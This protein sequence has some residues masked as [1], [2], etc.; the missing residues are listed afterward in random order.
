MLTLPLPLIVALILGFLATR[1]LLEG[2]RSGLFLGLLLVCALQALIVSLTQHYGVGGLRAVQPVT[3]T[4]APVLA[5]LSFQ[6]AALRP[7]SV[8][9]DW[10][11]GLSPV[12]LGLCVAVA[13]QLIDVALP[14]IFAGYA[15]AMFVVL[16]RGEVM[17]RARLAAGPVPRRLWTAIAVMLLLS[18]ASDVLISVAFGLGYGAWPPII[19]SIF[20]SVTLLGIGL[21]SLSPNVETDPEPEAPDAADAAAPTEEEIALIARLDAHMVSARPYLDP[22]LTLA[23][24]ARQLHVPI[25]QLSAAINRH[26]GENVSRYV[27]RFRVTDA[28]ERLRAGATVTEAMLASGFN[29]K[30]NFNREFARVAEQTPSAFVASLVR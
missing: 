23:R 3:A 12:F 4:L 21:V 16:R 11:H 26:K 5:W 13:P 2:D 28:C 22:D 1:R 19:V 30:S 25:K 18:A 20:T 8:A 7:P 14:L 10:V 27:N 6:S 29:T 17:E 24:L 15:V 9:R